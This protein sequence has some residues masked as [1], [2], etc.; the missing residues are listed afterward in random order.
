MSP[1]VFVI[2]LEGNGGG[3][4]GSADVGC[5]VGFGRKNLIFILTRLNK[6]SFKK[7]TKITTQL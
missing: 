4:D 2:I 1:A 5:G 7:K 6:N 3:G